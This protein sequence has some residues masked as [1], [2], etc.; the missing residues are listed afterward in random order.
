M[1]W[2]FSAGT[3]DFLFC[4]LL[5]KVF[6]ICIFKLIMQNNQWMIFRDT[7]NFKK[8][9][10]SH[11]DYGWEKLHGNRKPTDR[12]YCELINCVLFVFVNLI[13]KVVITSKVGLK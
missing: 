9:Q 10:H 3:S 6:V 7:L 5:I 4:N 2:N 11:L 8:A 12:I 1:Q 13:L